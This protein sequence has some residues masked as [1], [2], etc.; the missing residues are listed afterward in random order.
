MGAMSQKAFVGLALV[1]CLPIP[2][3]QSLRVS[4]LPLKTE[5]FAAKAIADRPQLDSNTTLLCAYLRK[6][7]ISSY[8][9]HISHVGA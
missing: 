8:Y 7:L 1:G 5:E 9:R 6:A 2:L 4:F 3:T